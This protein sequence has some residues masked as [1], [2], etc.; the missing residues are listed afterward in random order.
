[1]LIVAVQHLLAAALAAGPSIVSAFD[2]SF[3]G[4]NNADCTLQVNRATFFEPHTCSGFRLWSMASYKLYNHGDPCPDGK[5]LQITFFSGDG[6]W[7]NVCGLDPYEVMTVGEDD[8]CL[9]TPEVL[10]D[11]WPVSAEVACV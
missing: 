5:T 9:T 8:S 4:F 11:T 1:M 10:L 7:D 6:R 3:V 2:V